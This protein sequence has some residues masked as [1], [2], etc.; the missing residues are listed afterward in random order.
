M[1]H[2]FRHLLLRQRPKIDSVRESV[3]PKLIHGSRKAGTGTAGGQ[4]ACPPSR[5]HV[6]DNAC[7]GV[8]KVMG[9]VDYQQERAVFG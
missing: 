1:S 9:V 2:R 4:H 8:I 5:N 3:V 7:C 6:N